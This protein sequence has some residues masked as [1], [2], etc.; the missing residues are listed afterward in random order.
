MQ[1]GNATIIAEGDQVYYGLDAG[2]EPNGPNLPKWPAFAES[3]QKV[4]LFDASPSAR[5]VPN[6]EKL[7]AYDGYILW[8][9]EQAKKNSK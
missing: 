4:M 2:K 3:D 6:L 1:K 8:L 9:R 5:P 7:K